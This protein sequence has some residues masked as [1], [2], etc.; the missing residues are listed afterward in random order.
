MAMG[1]MLTK[2]VWHIFCTA[3]MLTLVL[4]PGGIPEISVI[5]QSGAP[6]TITSSVWFKG[7]FPGRVC[8]NL[9]FSPDSEN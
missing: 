8:N 1:G 7:N 3:D 4:S 2:I 9:S 6:I 5:Y